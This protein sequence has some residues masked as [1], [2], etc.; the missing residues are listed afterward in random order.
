MLRLCLDVYF[1]HQIITRAQQRPGADQRP[2]RALFETYDEL[3]AQYG[4]TDPG[5]AYLRFLFKVGSKSTPGSGLYEKFENVLQQMGIEIQFEDEADGG[6]G[7]ATYDFPPSF[8]DT[9]REDTVE[10]TLGPTHRR[11]A[12]FNS[13]YDIGEDGTQ[14]SLLNRPSSRSSLS[15][16]Q[17]GKPEFLESG[18]LPGRAEN[19]GYDA[20]PD[21]SQLI[22][23]FLDVVRTQMNRMEMLESRKEE[24]SAPANGHVAR[25]AVDRDRTETMNAISQA[26][27]RHSSGSWSSSDGDDGTVP[28]D[29]DNDSIERPEVPLDMFHRPSISDLLR[30]AST[31]NEY[32]ERAINRRFLIQ[33]LETAVRMQQTRRDMEIAAVN[34]DRIILMRQAFETWRAIVRRRQQAART[35]RFFKHIEERA[36]RARDLYLMTK[37]FTH[38]AEIA[39]DEAAKTSAA[40]QHVLSFKYF[41]AWREITAVNE[42]KAQRFALRRPF[43]AWK[44]RVRQIREAEAD[45]V[46]TRNKHL[47]KGA[48][49]NWFWRFAEQRA[50]QWYDYRLTRRSLLSWLRTLRTNREQAH[51]IE[52]RNRRFELGSV[53]QIW[54]RRSKTITNSERE[55]ESRQCQKLLKDNFDEWRVQSRLAPASF[56]V[57]D[58]VGERI[59]RG[60]F[61]RWVSRAQMLQQA[62]EWDRRRIMRNAW[63]TWNDLLRCQALSARIDERLKMETM[64]KWI[65][66]ERYRLMQRIRDQRI[67]RDVFAKFVTNIRATYSELLQRA[68]VHED[69]RIEEVLRSKLACWREKLALQRQREYLAFEFYAPRLEDEAIVAWR[70]KHQHISKIEGN[71][72]DARFYFLMTRMLKQ[73]HAARLESSKQRRQEAY[74]KTRRK[75]KIN[76][77]SKAIGC[78]WSRAQHILEMEQQALEYSRGKI[79]TIAP[80][81]LNRWHG[82][83]AKQVQDCQDADIYH[84]RQIAYDQLTRWSEVFMEVHE[85]E[86]RADHFHRLHALGQA[87]AQLRKLSLRI[88]QIRSTG[89]MA[90][91]MRV[92]TSRKHSRNMFRYWLEATRLRLEARD[93]AG[94]VLTPA[95]H[96]DGAASGGG[97][98]ALFDPW[99]QDETPFK[100]SDL[101]RSSQ[102]PSPTPLATPSYMTSPSKRSARA[103]ALAQISTTPATPMIT[104]FATR[105]L[106]AEVGGSSKIGSARPGRSGRRS[107]LGTSVRFADEEP[108]SPSDGRKSANRRA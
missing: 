51:T 92:R 74:A 65:L 19:R 85:L 77:A 93:S 96:F 80:D 57:S 67:A 27:S 62:V 100:F 42:L 54:Y 73:W 9:W 13:L 70:S 94:P 107:S 108:E 64:Y 90:D 99:Y 11:R 66:A 79:L 59:L 101:A 8:V 12:S 69:Y 45:A 91:S 3:V 41:N 49:W 103:R 87:S 82:K 10:D 29:E 24:K 89:E 60:A 35:E 1:L 106:R 95:K 72:R 102:G 30:D 15:R 31:F 21:R 50:P 6:T 25:S 7:D 39:Y 46:A 36:G 16:L 98:Q 86:Q 47:K 76:L 2:S 78:W 22:R 37:A 17:T 23:E 61:T 75:I 58:M 104:P 43:N 71:A 34:R 26:R 18:H 28:Q 83:T 48:Y 32:R 44:R 84:S 33:W 52:T 68:D 20:A 56:R 63:T 14:R 53:M 55:A 81:F 5:Q 88:F 38:W 97:G 4:V 40:R 105:L